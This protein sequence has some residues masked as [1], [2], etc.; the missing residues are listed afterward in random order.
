MGLLLD[1][2]RLVDGRSSPA[3]AVTPRI[4]V[5]SGRIAAAE[6]A[7]LVGDPFE[8]MV[9]FVAD[10]DLRLVALGGELHADA[11]ELLIEQGSRQ[12]SLWGGNYFP[13]LGPQDCIQYTSLIN[14]RPSQGNRTMLVEDARV[15]EHIRELVFA[16]VGQGEPLP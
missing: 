8:D 4:V 1:S 16:F 13:G 9:K 5:V 12:A 6:L 3:M 11:E 10:L 14:I 2:E 7:R 15:R